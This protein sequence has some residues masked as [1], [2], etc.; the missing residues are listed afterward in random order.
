[1]ED[2]FH[3]ASSFTGD[4]SNWDVSGITDTDH[5]FYSYIVWR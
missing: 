4:I 5:M 2:M 1:M 3:A